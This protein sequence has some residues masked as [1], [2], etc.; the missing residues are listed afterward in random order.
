[1]WRWGC[2]WWGRPLVVEAD[3]EGWAA[4]PAVVPAAGEARLGCLLLSAAR[5]GSPLG[6][7]RPGC[8]CSL[9]ARRLRSEDPS[10]G[11]A[12]LGLEGTP[13]CVARLGGPLCAARPSGPFCA[14]RLRLDEGPLG[15]AARP[16][17]HEGPL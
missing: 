12:R 3:D 10:L 6:A 15:A 5:L 8:C 7:G 14:A 16:R 13:P 2:G 17:L 1:M 9:G 11:P 4:A